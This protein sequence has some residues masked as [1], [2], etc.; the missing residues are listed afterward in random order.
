M[1]S[2]YEKIRTTAAA[3]GFCFLEINK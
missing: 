1:N 2:S 3:G